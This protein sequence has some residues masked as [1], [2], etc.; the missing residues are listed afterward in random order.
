ML[1]ES[2]TLYIKIDLV[3]PH[4]LPVSVPYILMLGLFSLENGGDVPKAS[5]LFDLY[6]FVRVICQ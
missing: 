6:P 5:H 1:H 3:R 4:S 2:S